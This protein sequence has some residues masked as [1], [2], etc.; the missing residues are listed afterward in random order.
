V[1]EASMEKREKYLLNTCTDGNVLIYDAPQGLPVSQ[2][3][4]G[5]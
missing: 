2:F 1:F 4:V 3:A 5:L